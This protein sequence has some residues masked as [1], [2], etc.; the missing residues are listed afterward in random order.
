VSEQLAP[1]LRNYDLR[2]QALSSYVFIASNVILHGRKDSQFTHLDELFPP[3]IPLLTSHH[4]TL[5]GFTQILVYHVIQKLFSGMNASDHSH[6]SLEKRCFVDL[7]CY[8]ENNSDCAKIFIDYMVMQN[9]RE[10]LRSSM[11]NDAAVVKNEIMHIDESQEHESTIDRCSRKELLEDF[12][13][14]ITVSQIQETWLGSLLGGM[15][16]NENYTSS[17]LGTKIPF[18][19]VLSIENEDG[20]LDVLLRRE[21]VA[22]EKSSQ[23]QQVV[24]V[25]SLIDRIPNLAGLA[26]SCEFQ[27]IR[28]TFMLLF[29]TAEKWI[30]ILEVPVGSLSAFLEK[31]KREGF[32]VVGLEQTANSTS[33]DRFKFPAK[34]VLV[35]GREKEGIPV[36]IIRSLDGCIEIPQLGVVRSL[37]V[38]VTGAIAL[39]E[40]TRQHKF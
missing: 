10:D 33:L 8:L 38:H 6:L 20:L 40:Y 18:S 34:T 29:V 32:A 11:A 13:R 15:Y 2:A 37:N 16:M 39:W 30:P 14:K 26:R 31:K 5:R 19:V 17:S 12:Q 7:K 25:A 1:Q 4:H 3:I 23:R 36:E 27:L 22:S 24:V 21:D 35:L 28:F 9:T